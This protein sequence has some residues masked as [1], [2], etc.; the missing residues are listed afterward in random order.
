[1]NHK[2]VLA[3]F[4]RDQRREIAFPGAVRESF[5]HLV[6]FIRPASTT[7]FILYTD[8]D[9]SSADDVIDE[10]I[11]YFN[12]L[13]RSFN[14]KVYAHDRPADL[15]ERLM[16]RGFE[17]HEAEAVMV[18]DLPAAPDSLLARPQADVRRLAHRSQLGDVAAILESVWLVDFSWVHQRMGDHMDLPDYLSVFV[19]YV[20]EVPAC[21]GW[22]YFNAGLFAGLWGGSTR[23]EFRGRGLYTAVLAARVQEAQQRG[24]RYLAVDAG[25]MSR[26]IAERHG[27]EVI[28]FTTDCHRNTK[29]DDTPPSSI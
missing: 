16:A 28:T 8:L 11:T 21:A 2:E 27:F 25:S 19:A 6:R 26:P 29:R 3:L 23:E 20:D 22:T 7:S 1:M 12:R 13:Q 17:V 24:M 9:E 14:W 10:Q 4:D 5:P 18:L 15:V